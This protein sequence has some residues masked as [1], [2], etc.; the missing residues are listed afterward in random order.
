MSKTHDYVFFDFAFRKHDFTVILRLAEFVPFTRMT[1]V[2]VLTIEI[3]AIC[4]LPKLEFHIW[5]M[6]LVLL[7]LAFFRI[8]NSVPLCSTGQHCQHKQEINPW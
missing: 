6:Y 3:L 4:S 8:E 5:Q 2:D 1:R 7:S